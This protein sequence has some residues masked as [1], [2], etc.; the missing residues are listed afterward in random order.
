MLQPDAASPDVPSPHG[1]VQRRI[2]AVLSVTQVLA[3]VG[4]APDDL[5]SEEF[6]GY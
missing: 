4:M 1:A 6:Y 2:L 3:G 5:H